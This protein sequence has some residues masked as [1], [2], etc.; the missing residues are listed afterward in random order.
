MDASEISSLGRALSFSL[1]APLQFFYGLWVGKFATPYFFIVILLLGYT[2][3]ILGS[4]LAHATVVL[5]L[6]IMAIFFIFVL[7]VTKTVYHLQKRM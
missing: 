3:A 6:Y 5:Y 4:Y 2:F 7:L 1:L